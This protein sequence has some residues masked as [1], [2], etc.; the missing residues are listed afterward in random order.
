MRRK[1]NRM[2]LRNDG[3]VEAFIKRKAGNYDTVFNERKLCDIELSKLYNNMLVRRIVSMPADDAVK[4]FIKIDGDNDECLLQELEALYIQDKLCEALYWDRLFGFS[5][6]LILA[7]DGQGLDQPLNLN[8]LRRVSGI[9]VFDKRD[10]FEDTSSY[11][12]NTNALDANFGKPK[13]YQISPANGTPFWVHRSRM[14]IFDGETLP[15]TERI[16]NNGAGL[17]CLDGIPS[18]LNRI[19]TSLDKTIDVMDRVT[20]AL[21]KLDGLTNVLQREKG[22]QEVITRLNLIDLARRTLGSIALDKEDEYNV[23]NTPLTGLTDIIQEFEQYLCAVTGIPFTVLFGRS[24]AG[25]NSTG[26]SDLQIYYDMV[27]RIQQRKL[28]PALEYLLK[29][30]QLSKDGPTGGKELDKWS[31][32]FNAIEPLTD[33]EQANVDKTQAEVRAAVVKLVFDLIDNQMLDASKARA[34][35][36]ERGDIPVSETELDLDDDETEEGNPLS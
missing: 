15:K 23:F 30:I 12:T 33:L 19:K 32:K 34:Y 10:I 24:P 2:T 16:A 3:F 4:N 22:T 14:L 21:L 25:L 28:R 17:S 18:A 5:C 8:T 7:D 6:A 20:T 27:R 26:K 35:L 1:N 29:I 36:N 9:E 13:L 31:V 11:I